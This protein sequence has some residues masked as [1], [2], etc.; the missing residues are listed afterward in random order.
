MSIYSIRRFYYAVHNSKQSLLPLRPIFK[1]I[2]AGALIYWLIS[3]G[4]LDFNI[5]SA[6][7]NYPW[8]WIF[9]LSILLCNLCFIS[10]RWRLLLNLYLN[11]KIKY[12]SVLKIVWIGG[13]FTRVLPVSIFGDGIRL[14]YLRYIDTNISMLS[15][16]S[17]IIIDRLFGFLALI[18]LQSIFSVL[19]YRELITNNPA[20]FK[21][22][23]IG[24]LVSLLLILFFFFLLGFG[25]KIKNINKKLLSQTNIISKAFDLLNQIS[26]ISKHKKEFFF[27]LTISIISQGLNIIAFWVII[28][29]FCLESFP[30]QNAFIILPIGLIS[31]AI[32][33]TPSGIGVGHLAFGLLFGYFGINNGVNLFNLYFLGIVLINL[34]GAIP[35]I[36]CKIAR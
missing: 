12:F 16:F 6:S 2:F 14:L 13:F 7:V 25:H 34:L 22:V 18:F 36:F 21:L 10:L 20:V 8:R 27:C 1:L 5:I 31:V 4:K 17:T 24:L 32:P 29:P 15:S 30:I 28:E 33:L 11:D 23:N 19:F 26:D 9:L 35:Y 3:K